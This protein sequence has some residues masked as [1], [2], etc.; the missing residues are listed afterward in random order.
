MSTSGSGSSDGFGSSVTAGTEAGAS[1]VGV[2]SGAKDSTGPVEDCGFAEAQ[3]IRK[4]LSTA[5]MICLHL[6]RIRPL[7]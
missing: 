2:D 6:V 1:A 4:T 3:A 7:P 5:V